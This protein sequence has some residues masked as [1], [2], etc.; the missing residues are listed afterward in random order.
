VKLILCLLIL[1]ACAIPTKKY[2]FGQRVRVWRGFYVGQEGFVSS[3]QC[4]IVFNDGSTKEVVVRLDNSPIPRCFQE[5]DIEAT[6]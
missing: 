1:S 4:G 2:K 5:E 6:E 3:P